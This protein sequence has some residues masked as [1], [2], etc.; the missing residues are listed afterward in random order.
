MRVYYLL[1]RDAR[2][3]REL[4]GLAGQL[5]KLRLAV[6][7]GVLRLGNAGR[8]CGAPR[9]APSPCGSARAPPAAACRARGPAARACPAA[10][11]S[12]CCP[13]ERNMM[14]QSRVVLPLAVGRY[15]SAAGLGSAAAGRMFLRRLTLGRMFLALHRK[16][17]RYSVYLHLRILR[18]RSSN[19]NYRLMDRRRRPARRAI[20][21]RPTQPGASRCHFG[22]TPGRRTLA[23]RRRRAGAM[24]RA[25]LSSCLHPPAVKKNAP[26]MKPV[27][28]A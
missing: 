2:Q 10:T 19:A 27:H 12:S 3:M 9:R 26:Y 20:N 22:A 17:R 15:V 6:V 4:I 16:I 8:R 21:H 13:A 18:R 28:N 14:L 24:E 7:A 23:G 5:G 11:D 25:P 1:W